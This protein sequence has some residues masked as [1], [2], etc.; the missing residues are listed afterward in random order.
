MRRFW[1]ILLYFGMFLVLV[2][3]FNR[4]WGEDG[5]I[6]CQPD[7]F[8][9]VR[10]YPGK[11]GRIVGYLELGDAVQTGRNRN[12]Y[13]HVTGISTEGGEGWVASGYIVTDAPQIETVEAKVDADGR[14]AC[15]RAIGGNRRKWLHAG[16]Q[17]TLY[18]SSAEWSITS[19]GFVRTQYILAER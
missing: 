19:E 1:E 4:A 6:M 15:R 18:A 9:N 17:L 3:L 2:L 11:G 8:V 7:S 10:E 12:G 14:V 16:D 5:W 13:T